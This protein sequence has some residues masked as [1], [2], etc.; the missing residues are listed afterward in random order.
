MSEEVFSGPAVSLFEMLEA[1]EMRAKRQEDLLKEYPDATLL[2]ATMNIPGPVKNSEVLSQ[3]FSQMI[4]CIKQKLSFCPIITSAE[5]NYKTG[6]EFYLVVDI[7]P[8]ILKKNMV[9]LEEN[10]AYG[11]LFDLDVHYY[12]EGLQS[13][14]R[15]DIGFLPRRCLICQ[16][17]AKE[18]GRQRRHSIEDMQVKVTEIIDKKEG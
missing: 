12:S 5:Y 3:V 7:L 9:D 18:C 1:R 6:T 15:Q 13:L 11:R 17:N 8:A 10:Y 16:K 2:L 14:S 4:T